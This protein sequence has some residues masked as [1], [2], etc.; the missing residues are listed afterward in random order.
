MSK[1]IF[2]IRVPDD[3]I[4][5]EF[6]IFSKRIIKKLTDY[7]VIVMISDVME[8]EFECFNCED[9]ADV[10]FEELKIILNED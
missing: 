7:H 2:I 6:H 9:V 8:T 1:P 4:L 10:S 5:D 3:I